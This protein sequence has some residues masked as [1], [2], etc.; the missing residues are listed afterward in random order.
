M[1]LLEITDDDLPWFKRIGLGWRLRGHLSY[2]RLLAP[3]APR[4]T[5]SNSPQ[6]P[7]TRKTQKSVNNFWCRQLLDL[8]YG[9][10]TWLTEPGDLCHGK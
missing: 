6:S 1:L 7:L 4:P 2:V 3:P 9:N 8:Y 10:P 5:P